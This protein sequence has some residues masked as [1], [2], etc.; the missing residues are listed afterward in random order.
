M[1]INNCPECGIEINRKPTEFKKLKGLATCS[2]ECRAK[3][4]KTYYK[5]T[6]NP[7][8]RYK[9]ETN[10]Q[11][12]FRTKNQQIKASAKKRNLEYNLDEEYLYNLFELQKGLCYYTGVPMKLVS[13]DNKENNRADYDVLSVDRIDSS[14]GYIQDNVVLC[15][16]M[17]NMMKSDMKL[18]DLKNIFRFISLKYKDDVNIKV[19]KIRENSIIF[20]RMNFGDAGYDLFASKIEET[21]DLI[22]VYTGIGVKPEIGIYLELYP[23]SSIYKKNLILANSVGIIDNSYNGEIICIFRKL[24]RYEP[25]EIGE[26]IAQ[27]I[28]KKYYSLNIEEVD[29]F[30][31]TS[32][33]EKGFG[34]SGK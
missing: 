20:K 11:T 29:D 33:G 18:E 14:L 4:L 8:C 23:R 34:S 6:R 5:G 26:R 22:K 25:I 3:Y 32:R 19:R 31:E 16:N 2:K 15:L 17:I 28:P 1:K 21:N 24:D 30:E 27:I 9:N 10:I 12:F 13:V 7:N